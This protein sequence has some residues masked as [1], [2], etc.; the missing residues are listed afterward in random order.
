MRTHT[1]VR[2]TFLVA[3]GVGVA[4]GIVSGL[5]LVTRGT[6]TT[7]SAATIL[8]KSSVS[9]MQALASLGPNTTLHSI[10]T[11]YREG[12]S[13]DGATVFVVPNDTI[14]EV[15]ISFDATG[16]ISAYSGA[17][18]GT[19][20]H[21][22][23]R[24]ELVGDNLVTTDVASGSTLPTLQRVTT[25]TADAW[26]AD[27]E[28][29]LQRIALLLTPADLARDGGVVNSVPAY[30]I[31]MPANRFYI[32]KSDYRLLRSEQLAPDGHV[33][34]YTVQ[35]VQEVLPGI[36]TAPTP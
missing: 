2:L 24:T 19:D 14:D 25:I 21:V 3:V 1:T 26:R 7:E 11:R 23:Q 20:G 16:K 29:N 36:V 4:A 27:R 10:N 8:Q 28:K 31:A 33:T 9:Q 22:Y 18:R 13:T 12:A 34:E 15:F 6:T 35:T 17:K 30:V 32:G 5:L